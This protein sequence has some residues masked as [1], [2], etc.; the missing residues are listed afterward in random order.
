MQISR[1]EI[2]NFK[3]IR[4]LTIEEVDLAMILVGRN[5]TG[6]TVVLDAILTVAGMLPVDSTMFNDA[7]ANIEIMVSLKIEN[8][9]L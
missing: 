9:D 7:Q 6:K 4:S 1:L 8:E 5:N 3:S 2:H